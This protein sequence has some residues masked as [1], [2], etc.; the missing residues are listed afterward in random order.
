MTLTLTCECPDA[1][2]AAGRP[3]LPHQLWQAAAAGLESWGVLGWRHQTH[4]YGQTH[5]HDRKPKSTVD[6]YIISHV[7]QSNGTKTIQ[8]SGRTRTRTK[9]KSE[10]NWK[11]W[12]RLFVSDQQ[13]GSWSPWKQ[14]TSSWSHWLIHWSDFSH[15]HI[16]WTCKHTLW[17]CVEPAE[18]FWSGFVKAAAASL[19]LT[20]LRSNTDRDRWK[21]QVEDVAHV[22]ASVLNMPFIS[23]LRL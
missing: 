14:N 23:H 22:S 12:R 17:K 19:F 7:L 4:W 5:K 3:A 16:V 8:T 13:I 2:Q 21:T 6:I 11:K 20:S 9:M 18:P 1:L 15:L 10:A